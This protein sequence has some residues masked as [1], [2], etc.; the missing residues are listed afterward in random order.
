MQLNTGEQMQTE[1]SKDEKLW[2]FFQMIQK[3][4]NRTDNDAAGGHPVTPHIAA[5]VRIDPSG[6]KKGWV[7]EEFQSDFTSSLRGEIEK[8]SRDYPGGL[9]IE[10]DFYHPDDMFKYQKQIE[11]VLGNWHEAA[12]RGVK[13]LAK[14]QGIENLFL[15][16]EGV[17]ATLS[18][19]SN[20]DKPGNPVWMQ[21]M[22]T[23]H[24]KNNGWEKVDYSDYPNMS[25]SFKREV[26]TSPLP[27]NRDTSCWK[28]KL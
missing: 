25:Q 2:K 8:I 5:W 10:G 4:A 3:A 15:H 7:I 12:V 26:E 9:N 24:P 23:R 13:E 18:G 21:H 28:I 19:M 6:G 20:P 14:K 11:K 27:Y 1:L 17:R 16:G 22:Y